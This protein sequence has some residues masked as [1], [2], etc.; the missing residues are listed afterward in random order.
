MARGWWLQVMQAK[1]GLLFRVISARLEFKKKI[2]GHKAGKRRR[3]NNRG[4]LMSSFFFGPASRFSY[5]PRV[6]PLTN[7]DD[8]TIHWVH[9]SP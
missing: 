5:L 2:K 1:G 3:I 7:S 6:V 8:E 4:T 9:R